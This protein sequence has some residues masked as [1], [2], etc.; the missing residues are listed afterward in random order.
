MLSVPLPGTRPPTPR[1]RHAGDLARWGLCLGCGACAFICPEENIRLADC[2][3]E[4]IR[5]EVA[6]PAACGSCHACLAV[7]PAW[8]NDHT[9]INQRP[10]VLRELVP[11]CG[12]VMEIWE[13][14]ASD[15]E[16]RFRGAS[17]GVITALAAF[18]LAHESVHG[19]LHVG[20]DQD[21]PTRNRTGLSRTR[22]ELLKCTGSRYAAASAC[23]RLQLIADAAGP[24]LF[25][26]QP[27][28]VTALRKAQALRPDLNRNVSLALS[29]FCAGSPSRR[30]TL[31]LLES[32]GL[33]AG[34]VADLRYRGNGWPGNFTATPRS[35]RAAPRPLTYAEAWGFVQA[36]RPFSTQLSPDGTGEDADLS[37]GDPWY[38]P[39]APGEA[40]SS[41]VVVRTEAG[42]SFLHRAMAAGAV[43]L[44]PA[45]PWKLL[46]SQKNLLA[47]RGAVGGRIAA[48]ALLGRP[49]PQLRGF[50]LFANWL[51]LPLRQRVRSVFGTL[52]RFLT[53]RPDHPAGRAARPAVVPSS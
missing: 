17:G 14:H 47:K 44:T 36:Y 34:D 21:D 9:E 27:S 16:I 3:D 39:I 7:C 33:P 5:P 12:P 37:C 13:G 19:V 49:A 18:A 50:S 53:C 22:G 10:G 30:G 11:F 26:G 6:N 1:L 31:R 52:R 23:D 28:E 48:L 42:R 32:L 25:I 20:M 43:T 51:R 38:R 40:G 46:E 29:F 35:D 2:I 4:G 15:P 41:L 24:C 8:E 45:D